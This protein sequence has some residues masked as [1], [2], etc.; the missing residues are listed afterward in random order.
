MTPLTIGR[1]VT[2][3]DRDSAAPAVI[4]HLRPSLAHDAQYVVVHLDV[5]G[6]GPVSVLA[7]KSTGRNDYFRPVSGEVLK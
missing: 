3:T 5:K 4:T 6:V 1:P 7:E 2:F